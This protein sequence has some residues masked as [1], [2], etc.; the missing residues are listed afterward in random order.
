M[1]SQCHCIIIIGIITR[2]QQHNNITTSSHQ[3]ADKMGRNNVLILGSR[4]ALYIT[5]FHPLLVLFISESH[6][7]FLRTNHKNVFVALELCCFFLRIWVIIDP[8][9]TEI[10]SR[11]R[12][13]Y[14]YGVFRYFLKLQITSLAGQ[15]MI[16]VPPRPTNVV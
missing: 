13:R 15:K 9:S 4:A 16:N 12:P 6:F 2:L 14:K 1:S 8:K 11:L 10:I 5:G 3:S 7:F